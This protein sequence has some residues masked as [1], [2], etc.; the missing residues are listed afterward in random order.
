MN[1]IVSGVIGFEKQSIKCIIGVHEHERLE[2]SELL[3]TL[4]VEVDFSVCAK[5]DHLGDTLDYVLLADLCREIAQRKYHLLESYAFAVIENVLSAQGVISAWIQVKK[6]TG[7]PNI[8]HATV[9]FSRRKAF[10]QEFQ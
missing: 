8:E 9:E 4:K 6:P 3:V 2:E 10:P 1:Q 5:S 7:L